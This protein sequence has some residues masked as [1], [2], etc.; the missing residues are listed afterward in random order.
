MSDLAAGLNDERL[1][2]QVSPVESLWWTVRLP[3]VGRR[4]H[5]GVIEGR[6]FMCRCGMWLE[7]SKVLAVRGKDA[8]S[9]RRCQ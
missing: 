5:L 3:G 1:G 9:C 6:Q 2:D 8:V 4:S 7:R